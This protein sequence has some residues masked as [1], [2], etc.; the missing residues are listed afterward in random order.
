MLS[1]KDSPVDRN[2]RLRQGSLSSFSHSSRITLLE[3]DCDFWYHQR[4]GLCLDH[5]ST[6]TLLSYQGLA[7]TNNPL[8]HDG[9][10]GKL[11]QVL[12]GC[13]VVVAEEVAF[14]LD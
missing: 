6:L 14:F 10:I 9:G 13:L 2:R 8:R 11:I 12:I 1:T 3:F 5:S 4:T 7:S